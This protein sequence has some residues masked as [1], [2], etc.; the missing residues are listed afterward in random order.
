MRIF[1]SYSNPNLNIVKTLADRLAIYGDVYYWKGNGAP[2]DL[3]WEQIYNWIDNSDIVITFITD[4]TVVRAEAVSREIDRA[5]AKN[6]YIFPLVSSAI[7]KGE[8]NF[9]TE[10]SY[11]PVV[12]TNPLPAIEKNLWIAE[13]RSGGKDL[14]R[15]KALVLSA[16][17]YFMMLSSE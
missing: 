15:K 14:N 10:T 11:Q 12:T 5:R 6:K 13:N 3:A 1:I 16:I 7:S 2:D 4:C 17:A 8:L 9:L